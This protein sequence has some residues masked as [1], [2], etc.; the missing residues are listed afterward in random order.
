MEETKVL[1]N[2]SQRILFYVWKNTVFRRSSCVST[3]FAGK[4]HIT[5]LTLDI[6]TRRQNNLNIPVDASF[7]VIERKLEGG[8]QS[9]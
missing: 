8:R 2:C 1:K 9:R 3:D 4:A 5:L 6:L 7:V